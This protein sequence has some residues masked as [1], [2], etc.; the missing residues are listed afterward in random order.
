MPS[1][2][3]VQKPPAEL[4]L[5]LPGQPGMLTNVLPAAAVA[6][7]MY[8]LGMSSP[9][10]QPPLKTPFV[11]VQPESPKPVMVPDPLPDEIT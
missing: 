11:I 10:T 7:R 5:K 8:W 6:V 1:V 3:K 4:V 2:K 9:V